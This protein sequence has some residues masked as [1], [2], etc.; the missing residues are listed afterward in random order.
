MQNADIYNQ[1][2]LYKDAKCRHINKLAEILLN[3]KKI[4]SLTYKIQI[5]MD[6]SLST[7]TLF[8]ARSQTDINSVIK[9]FSKVVT[10]ISEKENIS[11]I[12]SKQ[13]FAD[14]LRFLFLCTITEK[15]LAPTEKIDIG[16]HHFILCTREYSKFCNEYLGKFVHHSP[17]TNEKKST[18]TTNPVFYTLT[19]AKQTFKEL[20]ENWKIKNKE[21]F[22]CN[23]SGKCCS[24]GNCS[25]TGNCSHCEEE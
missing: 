13:L 16:W 25:N 17:F 8:D 7:E 10:I 4:L 11:T 9:Q 1:K 19:I 23:D 14:T 24:G 2:R 15:S 18:L 6:Y 21:G 3:S 20:S 5:N 22:D 12:E